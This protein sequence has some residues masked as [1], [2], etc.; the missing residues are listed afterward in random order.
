MV[1]GIKSKKP[2]W[3]KE[4]TETG[5]LGKK[6]DTKALKSYKALGKRFGAPRPKISVMPS[7]PKI[8]RMGSGMP[9]IADTGLSRR[10]RI[11]DMGTGGKS[12][13]GPDL[14]A[15]RWPPE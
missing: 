5:K 4:L 2:G 8:A 13:K 1:E 15:L 14:S 3:R 9:G 11:A 10:P 6:R 12:S 7:T